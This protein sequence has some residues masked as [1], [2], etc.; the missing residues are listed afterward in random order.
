MASEF[1]FDGEAGGISNCEFCFPLFTSSNHNPQIIKFVP[2]ID[3]EGSTE[4]SRDRLA[5]LSGLIGEL[6]FS[7]LFF[8]ITLPS[9]L[10]SGIRGRDI[11]GRSLLDTASSPIHFI[12]CP[13]RRRETRPQFG[14][15][16]MTTSLVLIRSSY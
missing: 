7:P 1:G 10:V 8:L 9:V 4:T 12:R 11:H 3:S 5:L 15:G 16:S 6:L 13:G 14:S 2:P